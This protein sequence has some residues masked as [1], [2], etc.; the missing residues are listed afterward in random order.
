VPHLVRC[1]E[2]GLLGQVS[3]GPLGEEY[4]TWSGKWMRVCLARL[5]KAHWVRSVSPGQVY[6]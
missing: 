1:M 4:L 2:E 5:V 3:Q 6:G